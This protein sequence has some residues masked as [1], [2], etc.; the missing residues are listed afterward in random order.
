MLK[1]ASE[2]D[3]QAI[4][5]GHTQLVR[6]GCFLIGMA[7]VAIL[8]VNPSGIDTCAM[9]ENERK[10]LVREWIVPGQALLIITETFIILIF[11]ISTVPSYV[12]S[13]D[14][15]PSFQWI[16]FFLWYWG[17]A[18]CVTA[19]KHLLMDTSCSNHANSVSGHTHFYLM[20]CLNLPKVFVGHSEVTYPSEIGRKVMIICYYLI[21]LLCLFQGYRTLTY[22]FHSIRQI[23]YGAVSAFV[24]SLIWDT[25]SY[26]RVYSDRLLIRTASFVG[27]F[28]IAIRTLFH[29][30]P[31]SYF[32]M[33]ALSTSFMIYVRHRVKLLISR[34]P[35]NVS[36]HK[37]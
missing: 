12:Q 18:C 10:L 28:G 19:A 14:H 3:G 15:Q 34:S 2:G 25:T 29:K 36:V 9:E 6:G 4:R 8:A 7:L 1:W 22:G 26:S 24:T 21:V 16:C 32:F 11:I 17:S 20:A 33:I 30:F 31:T 23:A 13:N 37:V 5:D 35:P 27:F